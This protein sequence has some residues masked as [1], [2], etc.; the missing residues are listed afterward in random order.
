MRPG[1]G[2][3]AL[4]GHHMINPDWVGETAV[5]VAGGASLTLSQV[6]LVGI[7]HARGLVKVIAINDAIYPCWFA[8][9][10]YACD[11]KWW[12]AHRGVPGA[13]H[14]RM[15]MAATNGDGVDSFYAGYDDIEPIERSGTIGFDPR[16]GFITTGGNGGWQAIHIA[17]HLGVKRAIL[18]A[19]DMHGSHWFGQHPDACW[20]TEP[21]MTTRVNQFVEFADLIKDRISV[22]NASP[23]SSLTMF[24]QTDLAAELRA[25]GLDL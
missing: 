24:P 4:T 9:I 1:S 22:V 2:R 12:R 10:H 14:R 8:D 25:L 7:A 3:G 15:R 21:N 23:G 13:P 18:V 16:P 20:S 11:A 6:R 17:V 19:Y 5:L